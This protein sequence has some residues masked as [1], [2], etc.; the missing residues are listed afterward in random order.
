MTEATYSCDTSANPGGVSVC[1]QTCG[2]GIIDA[3]EECDDIVGTPVALDGCSTT[4]KV[5]TGW[6]C[7]DPLPLDATTPSACTITCGDGIV[8][9]TENH[10]T[11]VAEVCDDGNTIDGEGCLSDCS[12]EIWGWDCTTLTNLA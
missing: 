3:G 2:N 4:C 12:G 8:V 6:K 11:E 10:G 1:A 9:L 5:E 7:V